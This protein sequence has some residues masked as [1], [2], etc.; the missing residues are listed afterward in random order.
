MLDEPEKVAIVLHGPPGVGKTTIWKAI[1]ARQQSAR[2]LSLDDGWMPGEHRMLG[3]PCRY[4]DLRQAQEHVLVVE[5]GSGE[6]PDLNAPGATRAAGE[7]IAAL[8]ESGRRV[9]PFLLWSEFGDAVERL[10]ARWRGHPQKL[11][12]VWQQIGLY[13]LYEHGHPLGA[14]PIVSGYQEERIVTTGRSAEDVAE[15]ILRKAGVPR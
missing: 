5:I 8:R 10:M 14:F 9:A 12:L 11:F 6:L 2:F 1:K 15:E 3:G 13:S 7:W 4:A